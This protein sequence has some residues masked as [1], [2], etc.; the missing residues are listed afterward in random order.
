MSTKPILNPVSDEDR[1][2]F[3]ER[4]VHWQEKLGL[5]DWRIVRNKRKKTSAMAEVFSRDAHHRLASYGVGKDW[6]S[7][8]V[9][10]HSIDS[11]ALHEML[12]V[13][14]QGLI[15][16]AVDHGQGNETLAEEH[17]IIHILERLLPEK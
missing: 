10:F 9:N 15:Q 1:K 6:G 2:L 13:F 3:D 5:N 4:V 14:L 12:H 17:R 11:T 16:A 8:E 7:E